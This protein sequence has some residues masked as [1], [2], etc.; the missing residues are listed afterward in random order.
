[1]TINRI[2]KL[3]DN[4]MRIEELQK[5]LIM[6]DVTPEE[7]SDFMV[8]EMRDRMMYLI[9]GTRKYSDTNKQEIFLLLYICQYLYNYGGLETGLTDEEY[10]MLYEIYESFGYGDDLIT[11]P[12]PNDKKNIDHHTYPS[13]RGTLKK[14]YYLNEDESAQ[15]KSRKGLADWIKSTEKL[16]KDKTG[17]DID[18]TKEDIYVFPKWDGVSCIFE[19]NPDGSLNKALTRGYTKTN[20][21]Q[22]IT[23]SFPNM[24]G[25]K[26]T[27][28]YGLKT[29]ILMRESDLKYY[30]DKYKCNYKNTRSIVASILNSCTNDERNSLLVIEELRE[31]TLQNGVESFQRLALMA[32]ESNYIKCKLGDTDKIAKFAESHRF[33]DGLRC[34]GAVIYLVNKKLQEILGRDNDKNNYEVAYKFTEEVTLTKVKDVI[35]QLG[36]TGALSP[37]AKIEPVVLKGNTIKRIS[38]GSMDRFNDLELRKGDTVKVL[39]DIIPYLVFDLD[40]KHS[41]NKII[42]APKKCPYCGEKLETNEDDVPVRCANNKCIWRKKG[43]IYNFCDKMRI[44]GIGWNTVDKLY[45]AGIWKDIIDVYKI[46]DQKDEICKLDSFSDISYENLK[47]SIDSKRDMNDYDLL[48]SIGIPSISSKT[49]EAILDKMTLKRLL[50]CCNYKDIDEL[51]NIPGIKEK[52]AKKIIDGIKAN[53]DLI[54]KLISSGLIKLHHDRETEA[55]YTVCFTKFRD[56]YLEDFVNSN[57]GKVV[58]DVTKDTTFL[59]VPDSSV[60]SSKVKKADKYGVKI[61]TKDKMIDTINKYLAQNTLKK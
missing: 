1:M 45:D 34:D 38:L 36:P 43:K 10:D 13:L 56:R 24:R 17:D 53:T 60:E 9:N 19:F 59:V 12:L 61:L 25:N 58:D 16:Y 20:E 42:K 5:S 54:D 49:F 41:D 15:N 11:V 6:K 2:K 48:G 50:V 30:N 26:T 37:I 52:K 44:D 39:Y 46:D 3:E 21:C 40:C 7:A 8:H 47:S 35:F 33:V 31:S 32:L 51:C 18:L 22:N 4:F 57:S 29:E 23:K 14:I 27:N 28:G 55:K